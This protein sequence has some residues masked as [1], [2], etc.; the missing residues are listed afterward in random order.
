MDATEDLSFEDAFSR[1]EEAVMRL[2]AGGLSI[3]DMVA[4]FEE[5]MALVKLCYAKL[6]LAQARVRVLLSENG[7]I[8]S[9]VPG[10]DMVEP[11]D[12]G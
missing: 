12:V 4:R 3:E 5:G 9:E 11:E 2:E 7:E 6:D 10:A 1:L 8:E